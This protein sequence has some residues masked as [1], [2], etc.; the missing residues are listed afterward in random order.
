MNG[1]DFQMWDVKD[2]KVK[3]FVVENR[4]VESHVNPFRLTCAFKKRKKK[5]ILASF[6]NHNTI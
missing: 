1:A 6:Q 3:L 2:L 4:L 5:R